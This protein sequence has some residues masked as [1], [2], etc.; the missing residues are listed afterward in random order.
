[1]QK[2][3]EN[4]AA[5]GFLDNQKTSSFASGYGD[6]NRFPAYF[7]THP[8]VMKKMVEGHFLSRQDFV[9]IQ[10]RWWWNPALWL[11]LRYK[12]GR[13]VKERIV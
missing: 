3:C 5:I 4:A 1:M 2:R 7:G 11:H 10:R 6:L 8:A 9:N 12:T 13:R